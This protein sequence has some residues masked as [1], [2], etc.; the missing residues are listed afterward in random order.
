MMQWQLYRLWCKDW[1][2]TYEAPILSS[3]SSGM[4][5]R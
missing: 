5:K 2:N 4:V 1:R 3:L